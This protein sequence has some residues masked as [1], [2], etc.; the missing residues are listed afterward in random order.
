MNRN[1]KEIIE[2]CT[3]ELKMIL[4]DHGALVFF[5]I[6]PM[7]YPL[8][9]GYLYS[10]EVV[11]EVPVAVVDESHTSMS[12]EFLRLADASGDI[13]IV[14][15]CTDMEEARAMLQYQNA[16][17]II[18]VPSDFNDILMDGGQAT[19]SVYN[20]MMGMLYYKS[21]LSSC[22]EASLE[23][24]RR[25]K[26]QRLTGATQRQIEVSQ[27][28]IEYEYVTLFNPK[29]GFCTFLI[30][31]VLVLVLQQ[32]LLLG[33]A[34]LAGTERERREKGELKLKDYYASPIR[35]LSGKGLAYFAIYALV[36][37]YVLC[38]VPMLLHLPQL[39]RVSDL[40]L[41]SL[42]YIFACIFFAITISFFIK[43]RESCFML[44]VFLS[45]PMLFMS[46]ISWPSSSIPDFWKYVSYIFPS[47]FGINGFVKMTNC[48]AMLSDV[49]TE[50]IGLWVQTTFYFMLSLII[51]IRLYRSESMPG[52]RYR[53]LQKR[54]QR[55]SASVVDE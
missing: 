31:A 9:Y 15:Y 55:A 12:R 45:V 24:N 6:V 32:T 1:I 22:T 36:S 53:I 40:I 48:G 51:Y 34:L 18:R 7:L 28:P 19:V 37:L 41:F 8:L 2:V 10:E 25:I 50:Y 21:L 52:L 46:G 3:D 54:N 33:I 14:S 17:C 49:R 4:A 29:N 42:P 13:E 26:A 5:I 16:Y 47:T 39:W 11:R 35:V 20:N 27:Q 44:F 23:M 38:I 43:E 30:P